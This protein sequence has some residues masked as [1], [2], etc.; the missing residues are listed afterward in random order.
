MH[1]EASF[2][3]GPDLDA[4]IN[5]AIAAGKTPGAVLLVGQPGRV[6]YRKAYGERALEPRRE[7]AT[8][9]TIY[10]A[11]SLTKVVA[12]SAALMKLFEQGQVRLN[13]RVTEYLPGFQGGQS[14]IT[15]RDL[16][17]HYSGL[18]EDLDL[19][20][21]WSG[22]DTAIR[23]ALAE[24]PLTQ[25][26]ERFRYS[27]INFILL[28]EIVRVVS[29]RPLDEYVE[30][31]IFHPLGMNE[32]RYRPFA[33]WKERIAPTEKVDGEVLRGVVDDPTARRMGGVAGHAGVFTTADD[34]AKFAE[35]MLNWGEYRGVR[36]FS[37]ATVRRFTQ[38][39]SPSQQKVLR[40]LG[41]DID[42]PF[43]GSRGE[44][45]PVGSYGHTGYTGTSLWIDPA[46]RTYVILLSNSVHPHV[47]PPLTSLR[48]R[49]A[50]IVAAAVGALPTAI[51]AL[52]ARRE[53]RTVE[54]Q[55]GI[56]VLAAEGFARL[57][58]KRVGLITNHT[59]LLRDGR[60]NVDA[61]L[62]AGV[63]VTALFSPEHGI[64]GQQ[65]QEKV[66]N[67]RDAATGL[68]VW[69]L[70]AGEQR[71]PAPMALRDLDVLVFDIQDIGARFYTYISTLKNAMESAAEVKLP[72]LVLDRPNPLNG[73]AVEGPILDEALA[74]FIGCSRIPVRH[75]MT[76]GELARWFN[77]EDHTGAALAVVTMRNWR[78]EDWW[79]S[80]GLTWID[81]SP[82]M[83]S[84]QAALLY[85]GVA[86]LEFSTNWSVGR[87]TPAPFE[88]AG[89]E[90]VNGPELAAYLNRR[91]V[92][93]ARFYPVRFQPESSNLKGK[94]VQGVR[95]LVTDR[96]AFS[97]LQLGLELAAALNKLYP[98]NLDFNANLRL[99]G[100]MA[101][102][103][104]LQ[105]GTDPR[106]I[107]EQIGPELE[108][109]RARRKPYLLY[110]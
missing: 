60:R 108:Q 1:A 96:D 6:L 44:L 4:A 26:G 36:L 23:M 42:S 14:A 58:G 88:M 7:A 90:W 46:S 3:A 61:M 87:G 91:S 28:G 102:I 41:W 92:R 83:R 16:L 43:S 71:R 106:S 35:M 50:T 30:A 24:K 76:V 64:G 47:R 22:Y 9:D 39:N 105:A 84:F 57:K 5:A 74:S 80:T 65:D 48:G 11:A 29:G 101:V 89:A 99:I 2:R 40:G 20:T 53:A 75:G 103:R 73:V 68:P 8:L 18:P 19:K 10:D 17:T 67:V 82:N 81:P 97:P 15:V 33:A 25:P 86:L 56:D 45:F 72:V 85:P 110:D 12:T 51:A 49:V 63:H 62:A 100:N 52:S 95:F 109:F 38:L 70:Y 31:E 54:V 77:G 55:T 94:Q 59:G 93:G 32:T 34:L 27:D 79:D 69:S 104:A 107:E 78:R 13:D 98:G 37:E 21:E 66:A